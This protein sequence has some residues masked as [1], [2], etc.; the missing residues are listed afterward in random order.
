VSAA[1]HWQK[2]ARAPTKTAARRLLNYNDVGASTGS[3]E[4]AAMYHEVMFNTDFYADLEVSP[5][6]PMQRVMIRKGTCWRVQLKPYVVDTVGGP[7]EMADLF[8]EDG[9][10][11]RLVPFAWLTFVE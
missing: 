3:I 1:L 8:F 4:E 10:C 2:R 11:T 5:R 6:E 7:V 9:T